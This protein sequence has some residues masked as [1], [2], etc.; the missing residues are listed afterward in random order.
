MFQNFI[1]WN[2]HNY[3]Y[4]VAIEKS[5]FQ[6]FCCRCIHD[7]LNVSWVFKFWILDQQRDPFL[8][9][10]GAFMFQYLRRYGYEE[11]IRNLANN[12]LEFLQNLDFV[13]SYLKEDYQDFVMPHFRCDDDSVSDRMILHYFSYRPGY[14]RIVMGRDVIA[15]PT[16]QY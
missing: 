3:I 5:L 6:S 4:N 16:F 10:C 1:V 12:V 14:Q 9:M 8:E 13:Q 11:L 2:N 7:V 15:S